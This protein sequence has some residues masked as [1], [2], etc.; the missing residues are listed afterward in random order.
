MLA[1]LAER[2]R[3]KKKPQSTDN[4]KSGENSQISTAALQS[5]PERNKLPPNTQ[6]LEPKV[7]KLVITRIYSFILNTL[8]VNSASDPVAKGHADKRDFWRL[9]I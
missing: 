6:T 2:R 7:S 1:V 3:R 4:H 5:A 8:K 9:Q